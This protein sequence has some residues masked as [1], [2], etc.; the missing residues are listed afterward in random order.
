M[1][2]TEHHA[3]VRNAA[4]FASA[5]QKTLQSSIEDKLAF[6]H[7][8]P[9]FK[10]VYQQFLIRGATDWSN[11]LLELGEDIDGSIT[12]INEPTNSIEK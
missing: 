7:S 11:Q 4:T 8:N 5:D 2:L 9:S 12:V 3:V 1:C 6:D 10:P